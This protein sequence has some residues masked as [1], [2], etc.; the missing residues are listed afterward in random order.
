MWVKEY[1]T[2]SI[3][4]SFVLYPIAGVAVARSVPGAHMLRERQTDRN[5]CNLQ[6]YHSVLVETS[7]HYVWERDIAYLCEGNPY[8]AADT[9][10]TVSTR[11][12]IDS[13]AQRGTH[14]LTESH[15]AQEQDL[16][17]IARLGRE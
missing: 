14:T 10:I 9:G 5:D 12:F 11:H 16:V 2:H 8:T 1:R 7:P 3:H 6:W 4:R 13:C 17:L 15:M